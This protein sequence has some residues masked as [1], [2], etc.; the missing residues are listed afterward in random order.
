MDE[1]QARRSSHRKMLSRCTTTVP[2]DVAHVLRPQRQVRACAPT[3]PSNRAPSRF[4]NTH[5]RR[6]RTRTQ[7]LSQLCTHTRSARAQQRGDGCETRGIECVYVCA[8]LFHSQLSPQ[9]SSP[10]LAGAVAG[11]AEVLLTM[12]FEVTKTR[13]QLA[14]HSSATSASARG[15]TSAT[16][17]ALHHGMLASM[18]ETLRV[19]GPMGFY[20][21]VQAQLS[22]VAGKTA[23]RF[24]AFER[25]KAA[26]PAST[27][28]AIPGLLAGVV[29]ALLWVAPTERL[30][31]LRQAE[32]SASSS[33]Q[34]HGSLARSLG[35]I[36]RTQG[37]GG[38]WLG[39]A[40][41]VARQATAN[42]IRFM[43][44]E[45]F[46]RSLQEL[47]PRGRWHA[48]AAGGLTGVASV[49]I[50]NPIDIWKTRVQGVPVGGGEGGGRGTPAPTIRSIVQKEGASVLWRGLAP[51]LLKIS[52]G[53]AVIF[54]IYDVFKR[55]VK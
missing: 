37:L 47:E 30:K 18:R 6:A 43:L 22:Q 54:G 42:G 11:S 48:P 15:G 16:A 2:P 34:Q 3:P 26:L 20:Y 4:S 40:P 1:E 35:F 5:S 12:P 50:T 31:I 21:G 10:L 44:Y 8:H 39:T 17:S 13:M 38:L 32:L 52:L 55:P 28:A 9:V 36:V 41:T 27:P 51:R 7:V 29:E 46:H 19:A 49:L 14:A 24:G 45:N 33:S 53:Q 25:M 23:I